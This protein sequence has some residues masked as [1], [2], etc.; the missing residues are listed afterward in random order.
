MREEGYYFVKIYAE[1]EIGYYWLDDKY[2]DVPGGHRWYDSDFD[3]I[4]D[5]IEL[6]KD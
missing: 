5:K 2:W 1:W 3:E 4:G 6:P